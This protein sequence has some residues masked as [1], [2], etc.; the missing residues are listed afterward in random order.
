[1]TSNPNSQDRQFL[2]ARA[3][4]PGWMAGVS[5]GVSWG[6]LL[7]VWQIV[8]DLYERAGLA[9]QPPLR[10]VGAGDYLLYLA[11]NLA[12]GILGG[13]AVIGLIRLWRM[14]RVRL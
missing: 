6:V 7:T 11:V 1:M 5:L 4:R 8:N 12:V 9:L 10:H 3:R 14:F 2:E 13:V